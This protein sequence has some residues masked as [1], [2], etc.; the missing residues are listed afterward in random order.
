[1]QISALG[2]IALSF[3]FDTTHE[4]VQMPLL[5]CARLSPLYQLSVFVSAGGRPDQRAAVPSA[6]HARVHSIMC[7]QAAAVWSGAF[8]CHPNVPA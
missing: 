1:M 4:K 3:H 8:A 6:D 2:N 7:A 5:S